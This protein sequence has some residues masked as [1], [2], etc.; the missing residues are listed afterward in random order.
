MKGGSGRGDDHKQ[1]GR[2]I[3]SHINMTPS[4]NVL[5]Q[6]RGFTL[7]PNAPVPN[8]EA[9]GAGAAAPKAA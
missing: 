7:T 6:Q 9:A 5:A 4:H 8:A 1:P 2:E 3:K